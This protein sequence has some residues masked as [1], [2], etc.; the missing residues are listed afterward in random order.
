MYFLIYLNLSNRKVRENSVLKNLTL[1]QTKLV[2]VPKLIMH[3]VIDVVD[4]LLQ[5]SCIFHTNFRLLEYK[6]HLYQPRGTA[7]HSVQS[8]IHRYQ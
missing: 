2:C 3:S 5:C 4:E 8:H 6:Y 7:I 1:T